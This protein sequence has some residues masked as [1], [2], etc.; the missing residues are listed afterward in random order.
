MKIFLSFELSG[1]TTKK[2]EF[3]GRTFEPDTAKAFVDAKMCHSLPAFNS[4]RRSWTAA[5]LANSFES[6]A[7]QLVDIDHQLEFYAKLAGREITS[8]DLIV[9]HIA[10]VDFPGKDEAVKMSKAGEAV[11]VRVLLSL[12]KKAK[13]MQRIIDQI[14][15]G[16]GEWKLS[17]ECEYA[18]DESALW[19]GDKFYPLDKAERAMLECIKPN[20]VE[21]YDGKEMV[22]VLGGE[23][24][25]VN[26][27]GVALTRWPKDRQAT[28]EQMAAS[29]SF[30]ETLPIGLGW[31]SGKDRQQAQADALNPE[32]VWD[33]KDCPDELFAWR[34]QRRLALAS[35]ETREIT[36]GSLLSALSNFQSIDIPVDEKSGVRYSLLAHIRAWNVSNADQA[37][38]VDEEAAD[39][40]V[41]KSAAAPDGHTHGILDDLTV[42]SSPDHM[43]WANIKSIRRREGVL[44]TNA[45]FNAD[46]QSATYHEHTFRIGGRSSGQVAGE[47]RE[48]VRMN[49]KELAAWLEK[50][51]ADLQQLAPEKAKVLLEQAKAIAAEVAADDVGTAIEAKVKAGELLTKADHE[52]AVVAAVKADREKAAKEAVEKAAAD[53]AAAD[54]LAARLDQVKAAKIDPEK[55]RVA[56]AAI[57]AGE[58]G[59]K[60]FK[61]QLELWSQLAA[62]AGEPAKKDDK[63]DSASAAEVKPP[64]GGSQAVA[65]GNP[66]AEQK[67]TV[68]LAGL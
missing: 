10:A 26:F 24:G 59:D 38:A 64:L 57:P 2:I 19:D 53:K 33:S 8:G 17:M 46:T 11:P 43:H 61:A 37:I 68:N 39:L 12:Y 20:T 25:R 47:N 40:V 15:S 22:L 35:A 31:E 18:M 42:L 6:A 65:S 44:S 67:K 54:A 5:T 7:D 48:D 45:K 49:R 50:Q 41:G 14:A 66:P 29:D 62:P 9:G 63:K 1:V 23:D 28:I 30:S 13:G 27:T 51:A 60:Q 4:A 32:N 55:V 56:V 21:K 34:S 36:R 3:A 16:K 58:E 52:S